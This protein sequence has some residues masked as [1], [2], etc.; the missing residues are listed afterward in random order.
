MRT[1]LL[2]SALLLGL[3]L[4]CTSCEEALLGVGAGVA[5]AETFESWQ[6][7][8]V[9]KKADLQERYAEAFAELEQ[10][11][12]AE[13]IEAATERLAAIEKAQ[14]GNE[15][16]LLMVEAVLK[17]PTDGG[18]DDRRDFWASVLIG[19]GALAVQ[20]LSKRKQGKKYQGMKV[21]QRRLERQQPDA[22]AVFYD[23]VGKQFAARGV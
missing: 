19:G 15:A 21:A 14:I 3:C 18:S 13:A 2:T 4:G 5:G 20:T 1:Y 11:P 16:A 8:L 22:A 17:Y 9:A 12:D 10:A 6:E 7:N 23:D